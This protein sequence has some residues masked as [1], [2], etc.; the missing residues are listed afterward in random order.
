MCADVALVATAFPARTN[1]LDRPW[2]AEPA[3]LRPPRLV[4]RPAAGARGGAAAGDVARARG[5]VGRVRRPASSGRRGRPAGGWLWRWVEWFTGLLAGRV[6]S[7]T[8]LASLPLVLRGARLLGACWPLGAGAGRDLSRAWPTS[9]RGRRRLSPDAGPG[10][11]CLPVAVADAAR[12]PGSRARA[13][14]S[15]LRMSRARVL[16]PMRI[17]VTGSIAYDYLMSFPGS[18]SEHLL[19]EHLSRVSVSF[20]VDTMDKRRGG[21]APNI[22]YTL[23]LLGERPAIMA[24]AGQD[25]PGVPPVARRGRRRHL[26]GAR[27]RREVQRLV[28]LQHRPRQQPDR[29]V[30]HRARWPTRRSCRSA[31]RAPAT[32]PSCRPTTR[33]RWSSSPTSAATLGIRYIYDP[34]QQC[35]RSTA[36]ELRA[37]SSAPY[38]LIVN[39]Y[40]FELIRQK[41]GLDEAAIL[42]Q[43]SAVIV[44][45]GERG[46]TDLPGGPQHRRAGGGAGARGRSHG[47]R[48]RV[49]RGPDEGAGPRRGLR[50]VRPAGHAWLRRTRSST[51]AA[52]AIASRGAEFVARYE[53][54]FR[55]AGG[56]R[57]GVTCRTNC[58]V[59]GQSRRPSATPRGDRGL[60][61]R[62]SGPSTPPPSGTAGARGAGPRGSWPSPQ[63][64]LA[65]IVMAPLARRRGRPA[66]GRRPSCSPP[67]AAALCHQQL[68]RSF[69]SHGQPWPVCARC[70]GLYAGAAAGAWCACCGRAG[71]AA[72]GPPARKASDGPCSRRR[73]RRRRRGRVEFAGLAG[74]LEPQ[75]VRPGAAAG[76][77][78]R[79]TG[80]G[81]GCRAGR[82]G[83]AFAPA[84]RRVEAGPRLRRPA[85]RRARL[86]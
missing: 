85:A 44:T 53:R 14:V 32:S 13:G 81:D 37:G 76:R 82:V 63:A 62:R 46:S 64:W 33:R 1:W 80:H 28:L 30:L 78:G 7:A 56:P 71:R 39:D 5:A 20:L 27:G 79:G 84:A 18:F 17:I 9:R 11:E 70:T 58:A 40:E 42:K 75:P 15:A 55:H 72:R 25:F 57:L 38:I 31:T 8:E 51:S 19:P 74:V 36:D 29:V 2:R 68:A 77:R 86:V 43:S 21:C 34:G 35:A 66:L 45:R 4:A 54:A 12:R 10:V 73:R 41:T 69:H 83:P 6:A 16:V 50:D 52:R 23:A 22:A 59:D 49:P 48:R 3:F 26:A 60:A 47:R 67:R 61:R 65:V 24:T